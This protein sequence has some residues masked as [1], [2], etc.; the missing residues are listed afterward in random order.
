VNFQGLSDK[1]TLAPGQSKSLDAGVYEN[2]IIIN[3]IYPNPEGVDNTAGSFSTWERVELKNIGTAD[4]N[5]GGWTIRD[6][7]PS[8]ILATIPANTIISPGDYLVVHIGGS[9]SGI[10]NSKNEIVPLDNYAGVEMDQVGPLS[11]KDKEGLSYSCLPDASDNWGFWSDPTFGGSLYSQNLP[12]APNMGMDYGDAPLTFKTLRQ[13]YGARHF[14]TGPYL[15][16]SVDYEPD[17]KV[18]PFADGDGADEDGATFPGHIITGRQYSFS[19]TASAPG[20]LQAWMDFDGDLN[21]FDKSEQIATNQALSAGVQSISFEVPADAKAGYTYLRLRFSSSPGLDFFGPAPDGEVEDYRVEIKYG[22]GDYV[23]VDKDGNGQQDAGEKGLKGVTVNLRDGAD[24][25][26]ASQTTDGDGGYLFESPAQGDYNLEFLPPEGYSI[27]SKDAGTDDEK[28]SDADP[29]TQRAGPVAVVAGSSDFSWDAGFYQPV[30]ISGL[31]FHDKNANGQKD[32]DEPPLSGWDIQLKDSSDKLLQTVT[33]SA[34]PGKEGIYEFVNLQPGTYRVYE[35]PQKGWV[36]TAPAEEYYTITLTNMPSRRNFFGNNHLAISG[37]KFHDKNANGQKDDDEPPL[38]G[39][40]IQLK[41][42]GDNILQTTTT[43]AEPGKEGTYE[44]VDLQPGTYRVYEVQKNGWVQTFPQEPNHVVTLDKMHAEGKDFGN[45]IATGF[46]GMKFEDK[47]GNGAKDSDEPGLES[48]NINLKKGDTVIASTQTLADGIYS[49]AD[50]APGSYTV[51]EAAQP[52]WTQ[53]YPASGSQTFNLVSGAAGPTN[54]DFGNNRPEEAI[55][56]KLTADPQTGQPGEEIVFTI[57]ITRRNDIL[58]GSLGAVHTLPRGLKFVSSNPSP[59][60]V[61]ENPDGTTTL[62]WTGLA[63]GMEGSQAASAYSAQ[64]PS[65]QTSLIVTSQIQPGAPESLTSTVEVKGDSS[66]GFTVQ[67]QAEALITVL[68]LDQIVYLNKTS[69]AKEVGA[70][71]TIAYNITYKTFFVSLKNVVITEL[72][73]PGLIFLSAT[74]APDAGTDNIWSLGELPANGKGT[75]SVLFQVKNTSNLSFESQSSVSGSGFA[76]SYRRLSTEMQASELKN[77]VTLTCDQATVST[78]YS[79]RL[80]DSQG[81][82]LLKKEHGSGEYRSEE[83]EVMKMQN[84]SIRTEGSLVAVYRPTSFALPSDRSIDFNSPVT[85][86]TYSRNRATKASISQEFFYARN[87]DMEQRLFLDRNETTMAVEAAVQGQAHLGVLKKD[88]EAVRP[89]PVFESSQDYAGDFRINS[90]LEDYGGNLRLAGNATG[91]GRAASDQ[92][93]KNSQRSYEHGSGS[94]Q[95]EALAST[96]ESYVTKD[97]N[98]SSSAIYGNV[99]WTSGIWS[100]SSGNSLL[101]QEISGADYI[102][103]ETVAAGL[104]DMETNVNFQGRGRFR[105]VSEPDNRSG[106][107]LDEEY[108][109]RYAVSRKVHLGGV[110]RF[111][112]PHIT[113]T[114]QG[115]RVERSS[116]VD[117]SIT[118]LND[119]NSALGPVYVWDLFPAAT[120]Y[121][122]SSLKPTLLKDGYAN[123]TLLY[124]GIGQAATINL[125]L[126][127]TDPRETLTN[128]VYAS[129]GHNDEWVTTGNLSTVQIGWL[130]CCPKTLQ[131]AM[132]ARIDPA[133]PR[134]IWYRV[135]LH[136]PG[137][138]SLAA[139]IVNLLPLG[140]QFVNASLQPQED[141]R[142]LSWLTEDIPPGQNQYVEYRL[143]ALQ[144]GRYV[145]TAIV[146]SHPLDGTEASNSPVSATVSVGN[147]TSFTYA[148]D[149]WQPPQ[150][151]LDRSDVFDTII[152]TIAGEGTEP[153]SPCTS[154]SCPVWDE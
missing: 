61:I 80:R 48:W 4:F 51:E 123:W 150:W 139:R 15:G 154:E 52:G 60:S 138:V 79:V 30:S 145:N 44:F 71:E 19:V 113:L 127:V 143:R 22:L 49:F 10:S 46:S 148:E 104:N 124:L 114:K 27:T 13:H 28:D 34:E 85:S 84:R 68:K 132:Q 7:D 119:G 144:D 23:W 9:S 65:A 50:L 66:Q 103:E 37:M 26:V 116:L 21:F 92:R 11:G 140:L 151:G 70:G 57:T 142:T 102:R 75:I 63:P 77:S 105:A 14:V 32:D 146:Q 149:G 72:A 97:L 153:G 47:N 96:A 24:K 3:E 120:E 90:S 62:T 45:V 78:S 108:V 67:S 38:P 152:D 133:E 129:G 109:G 125:R 53:S 69:D 33:T 122:S 83:E 118:V 35:V 6:D 106:V 134:L 130:G 17:G 56:V 137:N 55:E 20:I 115:Q 41:D 101:G 135:C 86:L 94:Y 25:I 136:N 31:K 74:P 5:V 91:S 111:D 99:K 100:K 107:D 39:W 131:A 58:P 76:N 110:S 40:E 89:S 121:I 82:S 117:Y 73:S 59:Q 112:R 42:E 81:T 141:G 87:L 98:A 36:R 1:I 2:Q 8:P 128:R 93:L 43:S 88:G 147:E 126:N 16:S 54:I 95:Q 29:S 18:G 64:S 12:G